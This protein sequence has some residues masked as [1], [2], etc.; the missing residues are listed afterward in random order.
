MSLTTIG[1]DCSCFLHLESVYILHDLP[2]PPI[3]PGQPF[4]T[5]KLE[6]PIRV[7]HRFRQIWSFF[8]FT[9]KKPRQRQSPQDQNFSGCCLYALWYWL[10]RTRLMNNP[11]IY[12]PIINQGYGHGCRQQV[13]HPSRLWSK[14][15][16]RQK[17]KLPITC[18]L[19]EITSGQRSCKYQK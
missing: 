13:W 10:K 12:A 6:T 9:V 19:L 18:E 14:I 7:F 1:I 11:L 4:L 17:T 5:I 2:I 3:K 8:V 16:K 15:K